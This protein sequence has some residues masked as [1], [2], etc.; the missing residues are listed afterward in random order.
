VWAARAVELLVALVLSKFA[1]VAVLSLGG[2]AMSANIGVD[3]VQAWLAGL[4]LLLMAAF[5][6]WAL[7]R[8]VPVAELAAG[9]IGSLR[10]DVHQ[11][12][13]FAAEKSKKYA[14]R[15]QDAT[16]S[17]MAGMRRDAE[18]ADSAA[19]DAARRAAV[20]EGADPGEEPQAERE[21]TV[22]QPPGAA[23]PPAP[24]D[25]PPMPD[26]AASAA[27]SDAETDHSGPRGRHCSETPNHL[28]GF[29]KAV[30]LDDELLLGTHADGTNG[31]RVRR[32][33]SSRPARARPPAPTERTVGP[34]EPTVAPAEP[35][36]DTG[37]P[38]PSKPPAEDGPL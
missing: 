8:F 11:N 24:D 35:A 38:A 9:A 21:E 36:A 23:D 15:V 37:D 6:P 26:G 28:A 32:N 12:T 33:G 4:V 27:P 1:I 29:I 17:A 20:D 10:H 16:T 2:A 7:L 30:Q 13:R 31:S 22:S 25:H 19:R 18:M 5:T 14:S 34:A 3:N